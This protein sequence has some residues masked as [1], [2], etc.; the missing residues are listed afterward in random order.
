MDELDFIRYITIKKNLSAN[1]VRLCKVRFN[2]INNWLKE[3]NKELNKDS[4]EEF[5]FSLKQ[6]GLNNNTL[7]T[8]FFTLRYIQDYIKDRG[9]DNNFFESFTAFTKV[10]PTII[11]LAPDEIESI[12]N[13]P[14]TYGHFYKRTAEEVTEILDFRHRTVCMFLAYTGCRFD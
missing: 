8:Y 7:N 13:T 4:I 10:K 9:S 1:S 5:F 11:I 12:I 14:L 3:N 6:R 2:I